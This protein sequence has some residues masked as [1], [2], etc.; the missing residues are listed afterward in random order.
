ML[1]VSL[2]SEIVDEGDWK[3]PRDD[4][5]AAA[6]ARMMPGKAE[7]RL[8]AEDFLAGTATLIDDLEDLFPLGVLPYSD[9]FSSSRP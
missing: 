5:Y 4:Q 3:A 7:M 6:I 9:V 1:E 2:R 8:A